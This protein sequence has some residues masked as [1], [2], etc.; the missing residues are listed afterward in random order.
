[1]TEI[2]SSFIGN[3]KLGD[4]INYNLKLADALYSARDAATDGVQKRALCKPIA[5]T[6]ISI[7]EA[8]LYDLHFKARAF[9]REGVPGLLDEV[10][11]YIRSK[12]LDKMEHL[13]VSAKK[14]DLLKAEAAFYEKLDLL[15]LVRNRI[16][17]QNSP[18]KLDAD[19]HNV[20]TPAVVIEAEEALER[21][22][23]TMS[24]AYRRPN[25]SGYVAPFVLPWEAHLPA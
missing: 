1:M 25:H 20:F 19:E 21:I 14:H 4:N 16:H 23:K 13:L 24:K 8:L 6:L 10:L 11:E 5:V 22:M 3:F 7:V 18:P 12:K 17:I 15:R 9:T 2:D